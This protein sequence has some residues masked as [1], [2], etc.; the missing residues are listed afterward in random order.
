[1]YFCF[2]KHIWKAGF[3]FLFLDLFWG[4]FHVSWFCVFLL[5]PLGIHHHMK[6]SSMFHILECCAI[7]LCGPWHETP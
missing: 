5:K 7:K 1:M 3:D 4:F 2:E 6:M